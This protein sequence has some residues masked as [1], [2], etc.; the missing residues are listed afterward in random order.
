MQLLPPEQL[1][2]NKGAAPSAGSERPMGQPV[3]AP[4]QQRQ[5]RRPV[6]APRSAAAAGAAALVTVSQQQLKHQQGSGDD[7]SHQAVQRQQQQRSASTAPVPAPHAA[8]AA[9]RLVLQAAQVSR[10]AAAQ[11]QAAA[12]ADSGQSGQQGVREA[13]APGAMQQATAGQHVPAQALPVFTQAPPPYPLHRHEDTQHA[14]HTY[15]PEPA[16]AH[17]SP[18]GTIADLFV[19]PAK[20]VQQHQHQ[21]YTQLGG[22]AASSIR[23][24]VHAAGNREASMLSCPVAAWGVDRYLGQGA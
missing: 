4:Q 10:P 8:A 22:D 16:H 14:V 20:L 15:A 19:S 2:L 1:R 24:S 9:G 6:S 5:Q 17:A 13:W 21:P 3:S 12:A 7:Q 23:A 11:G 18:S